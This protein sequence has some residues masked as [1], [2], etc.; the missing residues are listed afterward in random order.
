MAEVSVEPQHSSSGFPP[1]SRGARREG[2][3][4]RRK[5]CLMFS[6]EMFPPPQ[7]R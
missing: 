4:G 2:E 5:L 6:L 3:G 1:I 7:P